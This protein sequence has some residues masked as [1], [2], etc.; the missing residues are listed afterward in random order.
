M[1]LPVVFRPVARRELDEAIAWYEKQ[2]VGLGL[3]L[4]GAVDQV[5]TRI[6]ETP[7]RFRLAPMSKQ[8]EHGLA[9]IASQKAWTRIARI[10]GMEKT[11]SL[12]LA[13]I[14]AIRVSLSSASASEEIAG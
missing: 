8:D 11:A 14:S 1:S 13:Q 4:N 10:I 9:R 6:A 12:Q 7:L 2:K 5:L 3:E